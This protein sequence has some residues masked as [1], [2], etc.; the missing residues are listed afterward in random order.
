MVSLCWGLGTNLHHLSQEHSEFWLYCRAGNLLNAWPQ[1]AFPVVPQCHEYSGF[2]WPLGVPCQGSCCGLPMALVLLTP[3]GDVQHGKY[4]LRAAQA[5]A[6][7]GITCFLSSCGKKDQKSPT[8][9]WQPR[10][11][12]FV[13]LSDTLMPPELSYS[14][15]GELVPLGGT[16]GWK[17]CTHCPCCQWGTG[18][19]SASTFGSQP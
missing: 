2:G 4:F 3:F 14:S 5:W 19:S 11:F 6:S 7:M 16:G 1:K 12:W 17:L 8:L 18:D 13:S 10:D 15:L 9:G